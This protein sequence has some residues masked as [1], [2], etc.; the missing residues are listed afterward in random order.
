MNA[1]NAGEVVNTLLL[2]LHLNWQNL[3]DSLIQSDFQKWFVVCVKTYPNTSLTCHSLWIPS[4]KNSVRWAVS[5]AW[6]TL[7]GSFRYGLHLPKQC[8]IRF[9]CSLVT[10]IFCWHSRQVST[11]APCKRGTSNNKQQRALFKRRMRAVYLACRVCWLKLLR[12]QRAAVRGPL[13]LEQWE[14]MWLDSQIVRNL[15]FVRP[16]ALFC[17]GQS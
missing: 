5:T 11:S 9:C 6:Y 3:A 15:V 8:C 13:R 2:H 1:R 17:K 14:V 4:S 10:E 16:S 12:A 7:V